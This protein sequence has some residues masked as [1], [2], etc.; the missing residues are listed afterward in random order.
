MYLKLK[1][2]SP[3]VTLGDNEP[4]KMTLNLL[5]GDYLLLNI[6]VTLKGFLFAHFVILQFIFYLFYCIISQCYSLDVCLSLMRNRKGLNLDET[7]ERKEL[8]GV[9]KRKQYQNILYGKNLFSIK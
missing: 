3:D 6:Q 9:E 1:R 5:P 8:G 2:K 7:E 4:S